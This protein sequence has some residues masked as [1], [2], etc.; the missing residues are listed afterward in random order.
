ML[1]RELLPAN[2]GLILKSIYRSA[3]PTA[4]QIRYL[5]QQIGLNIVIDLSNRKRN[6]VKT[7]CNNN[8]IFYYKFSMSD[9]IVNEDQI[10]QILDLI[11]NN[12]DNTILIHC[13]HG[14]HRTGLI[15]SIL[16][17]QHKT[18]DQTNIDKKEILR[19]LFKFGFGDPLKHLE[20]FNWIVDNIC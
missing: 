4:T 16:M 17:K 6:A 1:D 9:K 12:Y 15:A 5:H 8:G 19:T 13:F 7:V 11:N 3:L 14:R 10:K 18:Y 2:F 20:I